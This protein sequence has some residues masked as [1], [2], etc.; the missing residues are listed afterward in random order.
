M[1]QFVTEIQ[2]MEREILAKLEGIEK[3]MAE[4][5][6]VQARI[7]ERLSQIERSENGEG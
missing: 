3:S 5:A 2:D 1:P 7:E 6:K 4:I